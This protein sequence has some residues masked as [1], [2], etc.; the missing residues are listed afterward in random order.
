MS[1]SLIG[2]FW[3]SKDNRK[4]FFDDFAASRGFDPLIPDNWNVTLADIK[5][6]KVSL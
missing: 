4:L 6:A 2:N 3:A 5:K 1:L